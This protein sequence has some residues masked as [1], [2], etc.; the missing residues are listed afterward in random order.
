MPADI[1]QRNLFDHKQPLT[2][3]RV[4]LIFSGGNGT[5]YAALTVQAQ[6]QYP[7]S[8]RRTLG[9]DANVVQSFTI[10]GQPAGKLTIARM[11]GPAANSAELFAT[12]PFNPCADIST[13]TMSFSNQTTLSNCASTV[14]DIYTF[15]G[16][17]VSA[18]E[19]TANAEELTVLDNIVVDFS[20]MVITGQ[21]AVLNE[22][23]E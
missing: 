8:R 15:Y 23:D 13:V 21:D 1:L 7:V 5:V 18:Y 9:T 4:K 11:F 14:N 16:A 2:A 17:I 19:I 22:D 3:D 12:H 10:V 20:Q 6:V